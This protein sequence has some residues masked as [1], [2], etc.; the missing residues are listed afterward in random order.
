ME[1]I[2]NAQKNSPCFF[3][4]F[5]LLCLLFFLKEKVQSLLCLTRLDRVGGFF[6]LLLLF[7][8]LLLFLFFINYDYR[9]LCNGA[10][11]R[12]RLRT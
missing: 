9:R 8:C 4:L 11:G 6:F 5:V 7:V 10:A 12:R 2:A 1:A 3:C